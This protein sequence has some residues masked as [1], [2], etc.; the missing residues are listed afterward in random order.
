VSVIAVSPSTPNQ[1]WLDATMIACILLT[2]KLLALDCDL[3]E[4]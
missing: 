1:A 2:L 4:A 3:A